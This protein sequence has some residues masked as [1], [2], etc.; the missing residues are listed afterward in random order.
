MSLTAKGVATVVFSHSSGWSHEP[1]HLWVA[2]IE[3][4]GLPRKKIQNLEEIILGDK[5]RIGE[6]IWRWIFHYIYV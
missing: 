1:M 4:C 2:L 3:L 6:A 5:V